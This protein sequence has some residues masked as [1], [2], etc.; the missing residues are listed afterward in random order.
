MTNIN[1]T[2]PETNTLLIVDDNMNNIQVLASMLTN[3]GYNVEFATNGKSALQW[4]EEETFDL[5]LLDIMM[6][7]MNGFEVCEKIRRIKKFKDLPVIFL[8][9]KTDKESIVKGFNMGGNDY[10]TKP[11][12]QRELLARVNT[13]LE[14][15]KK[16]G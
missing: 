10:L 16:Q 4:M 9:A 1:K 11:F 2:E 3:N 14:L 12:D 15:E 8:T 7:E 13:H 5:I 6:P